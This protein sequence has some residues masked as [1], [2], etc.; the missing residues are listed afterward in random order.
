MPL[1]YVVDPRSKPRRLL[2]LIIPIRRSSKACSAERWEWPELRARISQIQGFGLYP[3]SSAALNWSGP[4]KHSL[5]MPYLGKE[6]EVES[7]VQARVL[8]SVLCGCFDVVRRSEL[9]TPPGHQWVQDGLYVTMVADKDLKR[10]SPAPPKV[11]DP[12]L[13]AETQAVFVYYCSYGSRGN[14]QRLGV[15]NFSKMCKDW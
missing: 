3:R 13:P 12:E 8:R 6:T 11:D 15:N 9:Q 10:M 7:S 5:A 1:V 14:N 4:L 2:Q